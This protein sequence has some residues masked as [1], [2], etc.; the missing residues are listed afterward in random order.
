MSVR[1]RRLAHRDQDV[2]GQARD[3]GSVVLRLEGSGLAHAKRSSAARS[4][5]EISAY[6]KSVLL[7]IAPR[8]LTIRISRHRASL[9]RALKPRDEGIVLFGQDRAVGGLTNDSISTK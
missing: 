2:L 1:A 8:R 5:S 6:R 7:K 4:T 9:E 3:E